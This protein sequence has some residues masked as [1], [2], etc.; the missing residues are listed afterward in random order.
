MA[1]KANDELIEITD[2][3]AYFQT[4]ESVLS[5]ENGTEITVKVYI[6]N[7]TEYPVYF[8]AGTR[9]TEIVRLHHAKHRIR[10]H[11]KIKYF[12]YL[13]QEEGMNVYEGIWTIG[14]WSGIH[15]AVI[16]VIDNGTIFDDDINK[17]PY[18]STTWSTPYKIV[19]N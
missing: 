18:N 17:Y 7:D 5:F 1:I 3:L 4:R 19:V 8:P 12:R 16:D 14:E 2:P 10:R 13:G 6:N 9:Q 15:H 11:H